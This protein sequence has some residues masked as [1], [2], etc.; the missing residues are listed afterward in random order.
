M[1]NIRR[2]TRRHRKIL[3][4][5]VMLLML[6]LVAS[7]AVWGSNN[8]NR[9]MGGAAG[10]IPEDEYTL[11]RQIA[12]Y[13]S[14]IK[15][16]EADAAD[17]SGYLG[18]AS[19]YKDLSALYANKYSAEVNAVPQLDPPEYDE[20]GNEI[21]LTAEQEAARAAA[22]VE[23]DAALAAA[24]AWQTAGIEAAVTAEAY[25]QKA[26]ENVPE[27]LN[28]AGIADIKYALAEAR[29]LQ[30]DTEGALAFMEEAYALAPD[31]L[32]YL[33]ALASLEQS[34]G[35]I[36]GALARYEQASDM[37]PE[38]ASLIA[39]QASLQADA[40]DS[41]KARELYIKAREMA[42]MDFNIAYSYAS[43]ILFAG[44]T[45]AGLAELTAYRD[46][47]PEGDSNIA[48]A[49]EGLANLQ[50]WA[51]MLAGF[52]FNVDLAEDDDLQGIEPEEGAADAEAEGQE[53]TAGETEETDQL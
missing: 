1:Q 9:A 26:L 52:N 29:D 5:V 43:F 21:P 16:L 30:G 8:A 45:E 14:Y 2:A 31:N 3:L 50:S 41:D 36:E 15:T 13:E 53:S 25:Y 10:G 48:R 12:S 44:D 11:E 51:D 35:N 24:E 47:L 27:N 4:A 18:V 20:E 7:F 40:G 38:N 33:L 6:G 34:M 37:Y 28:D 39:T 22:E 32:N 23:R 19:A 42:P 46:S 49:E 17:Y